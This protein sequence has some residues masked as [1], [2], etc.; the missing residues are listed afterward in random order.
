MIYVVD[1]DVD[2]GVIVR[3][4][5]ESGKSRT[6]DGDGIDVSLTVSTGMQLIEVPDVLNMEYR[7]ATQAL[8]KAGF[9]VG[10]LEYEASKEIT[11]EYVISSNPAAG[12]KLPAGATVY[13]TISTGPTVAKV[14][15]PQ[16]V[17]LN[18]WTAVEKIE[19]ANLAL[20]SITPV[21]SE[22]AEGTVIWQSVDAFTMVDEHTRVYLQVSSGPKE[23]EPPEETE[24]PAETETPADST[25]PVA[26]QMRMTGIGG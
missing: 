22:M 12:E 2:A 6:L 10:E 26:P 19:S 15:M 21:E 4:D 16:L 25:E 3:Q 18:R 11:K 8:Q 23:T 1:P 7:E 20:G 24:E 17:G 9:V 13:L 5:P 14:Q